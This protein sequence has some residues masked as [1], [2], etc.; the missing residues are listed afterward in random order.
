MAPKLSLKS[1]FYNDKQNLRITAES[2]LAIYYTT[3][4]SV[5]TKSSKKYTSSIEIA[6]RSQE[7]AVLTYKKGTVVN[8]NDEYF[9]RREFEKATVIRA[10]AIDSKG[11]VS[12]VS[13]GV[14][15]IGRNIAD[16]YKNVSVMSVVADPNDLYNSKTGIYVAGDVFKEWRKD[17]PGG[18]LDGGTPANFNQRGREW[19]KEV[20]VDFFDGTKLG[21]SA[22]CGMRIQ[23]GWSRNVQQKSMKFYM[24][25]EYGDSKLTYSL[26]ENNTNYFDGEEIKDYKRFML[27][28]GGNDT[29]PLKFKCPWTQSLVKDCN[30]ATQDDRL[31]VCFLD[32]EYWGVYTMNDVYDNNY[33]ET[34]Y[35]VPADDVV[36]IKTG[37]LE[38]GVP[39]TERFS[40]KVCALSKRTICPSPKIIKRPAKC[41]IW[42]A[43]P[44]IWR[45]KPTSEI[46]TG[47]GITGLAGVPARQIKRIHLIRTADGDLCSTTPS[48]QWI[49]TETAI[50]IKKI[51]FRS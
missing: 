5:P 32:G 18:T 34:N 13:T 1:G 17:N 8:P 33:V 48:L 37:D 31:V 25:S 12:P 30:F 46:R 23:G 10:A 21:F 42:T 41:S 22:E 47:C 6:D 36:M 40:L 49:F 9:P 28:N 26:F 44:T 16:K 50:T 11:N 7:K 2:G 4:G 51:S 27:R 39:E 20:H 24:R 35:G 19:E 3:D 29:Y 15:F 45:L 14:Y 38:E 43:S